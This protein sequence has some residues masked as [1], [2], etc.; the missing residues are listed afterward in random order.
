MY[1]E[2]MGKHY[3]IKYDEIKTNKKNVTDYIFKI[4]S[5]TDPMFS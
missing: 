5:P 4:Y 2:R 3:L 1:L